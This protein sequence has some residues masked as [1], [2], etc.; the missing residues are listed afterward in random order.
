MLCCHTVNLQESAGGGEY[1][2]RSFVSALL[3]LGVKVKLYANPKAAWF[4]SLSHPNLE[5]VQVAGIAT[6]KSALP[7]RRSW[8]VTQAPTSGDFLSWAAERHLLTGFAH[9]PAYQ[10][11]LGKSF[12]RYHMVF[13][14]SE[15]V[16]SGLTTQ[17]VPHVFDTAFYGIAELSGRDTDAPVLA[18]SPYDW[19]RRKFRDRI[20]GALEPVVRK[21][22]RPIFFEKKKAGLTIGIVSRL[23]PIKQFPL[24]FAHLAPVLAKYP[25]INLEIFGS[26]GYASVRD[27]RAS[28]RPILGQTRFWG[29]QTNVGAIYRRLDYVLSGLPEKEALGLN[30]IEAQACGTP[31]IAVNAPPFT[32]TVAHGLTGFLYRDPREDQG[33]DFESLIVRLLENPPALKP[34]LEHDHINRFSKEAFA[35]RLVPVVQWAQSELD[36]C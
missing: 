21:F 10:R 14:V 17:G 18:A 8:I 20:L 28:L 12:G 26:G 35:V 33:R 3:T 11:D 36:P 31:V 30:L 2:T 24:M 7:K 27:L 4:R 16:R 1:Y 19:D 22:E 9:M 23:T 34:A 15:Y 29:H 32:E 25:E 13:A 5:L 6:L